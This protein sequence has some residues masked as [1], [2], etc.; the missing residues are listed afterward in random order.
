[1]YIY[2]REIKGN[3]KIFVLWYLLSLILL[4]WNIKGIVDFV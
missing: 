4:K 3:L 1:M 2:K